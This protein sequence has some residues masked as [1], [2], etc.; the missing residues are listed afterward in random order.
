MDTANGNSIDPTRNATLADND[1]VAVVDGNVSLSSGLTLRTTSVQV[2]GDTTPES[3]EG[4]RLLLSNLSVPANI[5]AG[6]VTIGDATGTGTISNDDGQSTTTITGH[7]PDPS[8]VGQSYS[9]SVTVAGQSQSP[10]GSVTISDGEVSCNFNLSAA[11]SPNANGQCALVSLTP[12]TKTLTASYTPS[13]S[14]FATS[15]GT[16]TH[17][18]N[19]DD[20]VFEDSFE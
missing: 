4:L 19:A 7:S 20:L 12:G 17:Q 16:A 9:V 15:S 5:P 3:S 11:I 1:Y 13:S 8:L 6:A 18:V 10:A 14:T 2:V